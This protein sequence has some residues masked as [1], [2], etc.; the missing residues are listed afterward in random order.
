MNRYPLF[1]YALLL[2]ISLSVQPL[3]AAEREMVRTDDVTVIFEE[4]LRNA[5]GHISDR[6]PIVKQELESLLKWP[7]D[8]KTTIILIGDRKQFIAYSGSDLI[9]GYAIPARNLIVIDYSQ[10]R[11]ASFRL[12]ALLKH[13]MCHLL[14]HRHISSDNLPRW[15]DE[16]ICQW[17]SDGITEVMMDAKGAVLRSAIISGRLI[18]MNTLSERFPSQKSAMQL[19]YA[20]SKSFFDYISRR[21]GKSGV[22]SLLQSLQ[23][24]IDVKTAV[25][26]NFF[27]SFAQLERQWR[28][29]LEK[30]ITW[31]TFVTLHIYEII[32]FLGA[33]ALIAGFIRHAFRKRALQDEQEED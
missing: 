9:S 1:F 13:E 17:A 33:L 26:E 31:L 28:N 22:L 15:L 3:F 6:Y 11:S 7:L 32:F 14:L 30:K 4:P 20:Q 25:N 12:E 8:F 5:A 10:I 24:N 29:H 16:G 19:A 2:I 21:F 23:Q 27:I 18:P